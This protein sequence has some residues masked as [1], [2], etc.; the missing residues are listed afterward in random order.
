MKGEEI[1]FPGVH[2]DVGG[3]YARTEQGKSVYVDTD[4]GKLSQ[5]PLSVMYR[6][7][8]MAGVPLLLPFEWKNEAIKK[9]MK[10]DPVLI[11]DFNNYRENT[12][13]GGRNLRE[14]LRKQYAFYIRWRKMRYGTLVKVMSANLAKV[15]PEK[16]RKRDLRDMIDSERK[17]EAELKFLNSYMD[18]YS[19]TPMN[20]PAQG[21]RIWI[22]NVN[23][24]A[25]EVSVLGGEIQ[26][27]EKIDQWEQG[28]KKIWNDKA[29]PQAAVKMFEQYVHD[30]VAWFRV[31]PADSWGYLRWRTVF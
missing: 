31:E 6:K 29:P 19:V 12:D 27:M 28:I 9:V 18:D 5:I 15:S 23:K 22:P 7:A 2:S 1:V 11:R 20:T 17:L 24:S 8:I 3:G 13:I 10:V 14:M 26:S 21:Q 25:K 30:S 16:M 4:T